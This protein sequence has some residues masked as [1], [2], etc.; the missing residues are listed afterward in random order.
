MGRGIVDVACVHLPGGPGAE[1]F[2]GQLTAVEGL[3]VSV[4]PVARYREQATGARE[5]PRPGCLIVQH[6]HAPRVVGG[7]RAHR[8]PAGHGQAEDALHGFIPPCG[9]RRGSRLA[10]LQVRPKSPAGPLPVILERRRRKP[11]LAPLGRRIS[12][13]AGGFLELPLPGADA[14][15]MTLLAQAG[16]PLRLCMN[17]LEPDFATVARGTMAR[18]RRER[19][20]CPVSA[21]WRSD[22][23]GARS[24]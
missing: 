8:T 6:R 3:E 16:F 22:E 10:E 19:V 14:L 23:P 4:I 5:Q 15:R 18:L 7:D 11:G 1:G 21:V 24:R 2:S 9:G 17:V 13:N 20:P 12:L